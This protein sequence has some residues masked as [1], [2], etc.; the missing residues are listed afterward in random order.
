M[1]YVCIAAAAYLLGSVSTGLLI[2]GKSSAVNLR[3]MGSKSTGAS[4]VLRLMGM[5]KG[6]MTF[7]GDFAKA[8]AACLAGRLA[9]GLHGAMLAG[10]C[11][12]IGHNWPLY[13]RFKGGKGVACS[14]AVIL[15]TFPFPEAAIAI[16]ACLTLIAVTRYI[17][18]GSMTMTVL[19]AILTAAR[20]HPDPLTCAWAAAIA[21]L[22]ILRHRTNIT[23]MM[24]GTENK[25]G[26][27][28]E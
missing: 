3:E 15:M 6:A 20:A 4:N 1:V 25:L 18:L 10:L 28:K 8:A 26:K 12:I 22:C 5:K 2:A 17:S 13:H 9:G 19:F 14:A 23:R 21:A 16:L 24:N 27:Q 11:C 7:A